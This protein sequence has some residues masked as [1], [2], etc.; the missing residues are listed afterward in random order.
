[1]N[2][3]PDPKREYNDNRPDLIKD[4][5]LLSRNFWNKQNSSENC[6]LTYEDRSKRSPLNCNN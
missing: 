1:M 5:K 6:R 2:P 3:E 4:E